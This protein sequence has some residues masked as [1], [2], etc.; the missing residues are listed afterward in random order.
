MI[1]VISCI[2]SMPCPGNPLPWL[3]LWTAR[4]PKLSLFVCAGLVRLAARP[5]ATLM[6]IARTTITRIG[7]TC[8]LISEARV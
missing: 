5:V 4:I 1:G 7:W 8:C 6:N 2:R 3:M